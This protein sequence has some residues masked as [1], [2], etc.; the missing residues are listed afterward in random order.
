MAESRLDQEPGL[1]EEIATMIVEGYSHQRIADAIRAHK[2]TVTKSY[3]K[4]PRVRAHIK[5]L[6]QERM[7]LITRT[8]DVTLQKR[9]EDPA[10][11]RKM[12]IKDLIEIRRELLGPPTQRL[13]VGRGPDEQG[14]LAELYQ[15][16]QDQ[17]E[18]AAALG[19]T[20][21]LLPELPPGDE[22]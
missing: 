19:F 20:D 3:A 7:D 5:R 17:P 2:T 13:Q 18:L 9:L 8:I 21:G 15:R 16:L 11:R 6:H 12:S 4:D 14:A 10:A 22:S 1:D